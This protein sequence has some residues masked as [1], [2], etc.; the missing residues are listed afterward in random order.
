MTPAD[1][2]LAYCQGDGNAIRIHGIQNAK[3]ALSRRWFDGP[4]E[5]VAEITAVP[6]TSSPMY[7]ISLEEG[8]P[9]NHIISESRVRH[10]INHADSVEHVSESDTGL[11]S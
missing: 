1:N 7:I 9:T 2:E 10:L 5:G 11:K 3:S 8:R 6:S 4:R